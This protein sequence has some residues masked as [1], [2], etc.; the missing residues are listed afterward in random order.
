MAPA[1]QDSGEQPTPTPAPAGG[2]HSQGEGWGIGLHAWLERAGQAVLGPGRLELLD[3]IDRHRS[4]SAAAR[5]MGMSYRRAW[6]LVQAVNA[7]A[8]EPLVTAAAGGAQG[9]GA[10]LTPVGRWAVG[11]CRDVQGQLRQTA[12]GLLPRL[13]EHA[14]SATLH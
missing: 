1:R 7:A 13:R 2:P 3:G 5:Q 12:A 10:Q 8:G 11:A 9:G 14:R 4:S 6:E